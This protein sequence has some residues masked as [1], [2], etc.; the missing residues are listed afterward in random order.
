MCVC[1]CQGLDLV[2]AE[3]GSNFSA[4][5]RQLLCLARMLMRPAMLYVCDEATACVDKDAD[6]IIHDTLLA[7]PATVLF[8]CHRLE[9]SS[10]PAPL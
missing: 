8:I 2:L 1:V 9:V 6:V 5:E 3:K 4:G 7:L 10:P